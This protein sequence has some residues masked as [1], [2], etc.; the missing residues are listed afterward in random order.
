MYQ[1]EGY[2]ESC[3]KE[4]WLEE[5]AVANIFV[6]NNNI[7]VIGNLSV[8]DPLVEAEIELIKQDMFDKG[9]DLI[10]VIYSGGL[11]VFNIIRAGSEAEALLG[12]EL[13]SS[14]DVF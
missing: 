7:Y 4:I 8:D 6:S 3:F 5:G 9:K 14:E 10:N 13:G 2:T 11:E 1:M 12:A